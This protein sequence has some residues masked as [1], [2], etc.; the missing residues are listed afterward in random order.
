MEF[1]ELRRRYVESFSAER[2]GFA[3]E[4]LDLARASHQLRDDDNIHLARIEAQ[5]LS[6]RAEARHRLE[7]GRSATPS[8]T[9]A[10]QRDGAGRR[11]DHGRHVPSRVDDTDSSWTVR[12][13]QLLGQPAGPGVASGA[14][15]VVVEPSD[16]FDFKSGEILVCDAVQ[17]HMTLV[18]PL[19]AAIVERRGGMLI[20]GAII[21]RE[22][23]LPCVTGVADAPAS[24]R[25]GDRLT[26]D[27]HLGLV[28]CRSL[29]RDELAPE[30]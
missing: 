21:A 30:V 26:V 7:I 22:Y 13:R 12:P 1:E 8:L 3:T 27:G 10:L 20:H 2:R 25:T 24:I 15:R 17:P 16:L 23:G 9:E 19:A 14:A 28:V 18:V 6:A 5:L 29:S 4:L 11:L